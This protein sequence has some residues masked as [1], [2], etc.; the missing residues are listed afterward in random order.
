VH[1]H[2]SAP[3]GRQQ[4]QHADFERRE[5]RQH[6]GHE[7]HAAHAG[8]GPSREHEWNQHEVRGRA[9]PEPAG[10][11]ARQVETAAQAEL[12]PNHLDPR[13]E[14]RAQPG[15]AQQKQ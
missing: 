8:D 13:R 14:K 5:R 2:E 6:H 4:E 12:G 10:P 7:A 1:G 3:A 11:S 9:A 15:H